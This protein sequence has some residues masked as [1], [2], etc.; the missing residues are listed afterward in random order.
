MRS[1]DSLLGLCFF[2]GPTGHVGDTNDLGRES[3]Q[4][5]MFVCFI[6]KC[7]VCFPGLPGDRL[8]CGLPMVPVCT[9]RGSLSR[10]NNREQ[11]GV[12]LS[13]C[14]QHLFLPNPKETDSVMLLE[15]QDRS[16]S[17]FFLISSNSQGEVRK[18]QDQSLEP[19]QKGD[20]KTCPCP[21]L[22]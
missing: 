15:G 6:P 8:H 3:I 22:S 16:S 9:G 10:N 21:Q 7:D 4:R 12:T 5:L 1:K 13:C 18:V 17:S 20:Q 11:E 19:R 14:H 2:W